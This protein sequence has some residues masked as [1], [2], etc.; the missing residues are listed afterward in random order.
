MKTICAFLPGLLALGSLAFAQAPQF[1]VASVK[2]SGPGAADYSVSVGVHID[3]AQ[4]SC[5]YFSL[6]DYISLAYDLKQYQVI[7]PEWMASARYD[8]K[9]RIPQGTPRDQV[10]EM[11][12][13]LLAERFH[14]KAHKEE[15]EFPVYALVQDKGGSKLT[16]A[17]PFEGEA[18]KGAAV[19]AQGGPQGVSLSLGNGAF[20]SF[21]DNKVEGQRLTMLQFADTMARFSDRPIV[22]MTGLVG[23]YNFTIKL[24]DEDYNAMRIRSAISAGVQLPPQAMK[25]LEMSSGDSLASALKALGLKMEARK[26]P[27]QV[28]VVESADKTPTEN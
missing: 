26:S 4:V 12:Q 25:L 7:A 14:L 22:D 21:A 23:S 15:K 16:E 28:L 10:R 13:S 20:F 1:E 27:L 8:V 18:V 2:A 19:E 17:K 6:H 11:F 9:A 5:N 3:G 24:S